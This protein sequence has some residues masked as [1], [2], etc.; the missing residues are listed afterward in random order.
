MLST[1]I[2]ELPEPDTTVVMCPDVLSEL[3]NGASSFPGVVLQRGTAWGPDGVRR[4]T[5]KE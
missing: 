2:A 1:T 3:Q 4:E 5:G